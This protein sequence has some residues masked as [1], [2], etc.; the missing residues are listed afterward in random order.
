LPPLFL[1]DPQ[2][3]VGRHYKN[4]PTYVFIYPKEI[5]EY[6]AQK[7]DFSGVETKEK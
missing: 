3:E 1:Q 6:I 2:T 4:D 5:L 7:M